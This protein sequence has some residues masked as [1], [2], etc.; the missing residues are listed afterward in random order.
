MTYNDLRKGR[1]SEPGRP[2]FLTM[3]TDRRSRWFDDFAAARIVIADMQRLARER[4]LESLAYVL[5]PDHLHWLLVLGDDEH[6]SRV[7]RSLKGRSARRINL[8]L[9]RR[10]PVWQ[11]GFHDHALRRDEDIRA[12]ARYTVANPLRAGLVSR[13]ADYP[14]WDAVW[15]EG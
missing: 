14:H 7:A 15:L 2:Y 6:L 9:G 4:A 8:H 11:A 13:L 5:M 3:V 1:H 12:V 10:G